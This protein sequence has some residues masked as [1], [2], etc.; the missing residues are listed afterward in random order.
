ME[1]LNGIW[2][3]LARQ[4][5][6]R[7]QIQ[8]RIRSARLALTFEPCLFTDQ[9]HPFLPDETL[10]DWCLWC[11]ARYADHIGELKATVLVEINIGNEK[12]LKNDTTTSV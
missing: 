10:R 12:R 5:E 6:Y 3:S 1:T 4:E 2:P 8:D 7:R 11:F 9:P